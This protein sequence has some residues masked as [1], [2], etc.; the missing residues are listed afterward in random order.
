[1]K[2]ARDPEKIAAA[3][4]KAWKLVDEMNVLRVAENGASDLVDE[5]IIDSTERA[6]QAREV[7]QRRRSNSLDSCDTVGR[8]LE[9]QHTASHKKRRMLNR[10]QSWKV[11][12]AELEAEERKRARL[13]SRRGGTSLDSK[14][15]SS[16]ADGAP[17]GASIGD[18]DHYA[19]ASDRASIGDSGHHDSDIVDAEAACAAAQVA[20]DAAHAVLA[21]VKAS[22]VKRTMDIIDL[23]DTS[24]DS[25]GY[26]GVSATVKRA[27]DA[28]RRP[29]IDLSD[30]DSSGYSGVSA[31]IKRALAPG[32]WKLNG[33]TGFRRF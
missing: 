5:H 15:D 11:K 28:C 32:V 6:D 26:S 20:L 10:A 13:I 21:G 2:K 27:R 19:D 7:D 29:I 24:S 31:T 16:D 4:D 8:F 14:T 3:Q 18:Y 12:R 9:L 1:M 33:L 30:S 23:C 17:D 25:S 22:R